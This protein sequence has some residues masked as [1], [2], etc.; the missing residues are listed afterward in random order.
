MGFAAGLLV[1]AL[2]LLILHQCLTYGFHN[3]SYRKPIPIY[4]K[5]ENDDIYDILWYT[6]VRKNK[7]DT[8]KRSGPSFPITSKGKKPRSEMAIAGLHHMPKRENYKSE[9]SHTIYSNTRSRVKSKNKN[10]TNK[11]K[12][13]LWRQRK[14]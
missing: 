7:S 13:K 5:W 6:G 11:G 8:S 10:D 3:V 4:L 9:Y 1:W 2:I 14:M 12:K